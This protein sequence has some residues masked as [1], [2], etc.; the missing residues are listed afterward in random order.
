MT[1]M[2]TLNPLIWG[3]GEYLCLRRFPGEEGWAG[4]WSVAGI[5]I[6]VSVVSDYLFFDLW[7]H[8]GDIWHPTT[9]YGYVFVGGLPFLIRGLFRKHFT[10]RRRRIAD[11]DLRRLGI[12]IAVVLVV[13]FVFVI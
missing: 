13:F 4:A 2:L 10:N 1:L 5:L 12:G 8:S 3:I 9:F 6:G 7:L 11:R